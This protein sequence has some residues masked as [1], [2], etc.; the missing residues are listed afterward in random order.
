MTDIDD[1][2]EVSV[3]VASLNTA[4]ATEL[5]VRTALAY[6]GQHFQLVVGDSG[7]TDATLRRLRRF[8]QHGRLTLE[9]APQGRRHAEWLNHW[10]ATCASRYL[11]FVDSD[12]EFLRTGWL[13][14]IVDRARSEHAALVTSRLQDL[15][16]QGRTKSGNRLRWA[17][18]PTP[19][20]MLV[21]TEQFRRLDDA[22]FGYRQVDDPD[23]PGGRIVYDTG[24]YAYQTLEASGMKC[25]V[26]PAGWDSCYRHY[27]GMTWIRRNRAR[28]ARRA[29]QALKRRRIW[30][31]LQRAR[32][33][34]REPARVA[35]T[36][37]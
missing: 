37:W 22:G 35:R 7:S 23:R 33:V 36:R 9:L 31:R 2:S 17:K 26:M 13:R 29:R 10:A 19:W 11:V 14:E 27:G 4:D 21:D 18:R 6:A 8:E 24:A 12:M 15:G 3:C 30:L 20:L 28:P 32:V 34:C 25:V 1:A 5:C 16:D